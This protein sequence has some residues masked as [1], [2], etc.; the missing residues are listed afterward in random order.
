MCHCT[1][2]QMAGGGCWWCP[3]G[4][5]P[6]RKNPRVAL[7]YADTLDVSGCTWM[8]L[9]V[10]CVVSLF[11]LVYIFNIDIYIYIYCIH[12]LLFTALE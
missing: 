4:A 3:S 2:F 12:S 1:F 7:A 5:L 6:F 8:I 9:D 10:C 11:S